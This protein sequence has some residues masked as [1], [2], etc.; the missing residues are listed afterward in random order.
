MDEYHDIK[1]QMIELLK[2]L[3]PER[4]A[5][6]NEAIRDALISA[7]RGQ[8]S[9]FPIN[10]MVNLSREEAQRICRKIGLDWETEEMS[11]DE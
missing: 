1:E 10:E 3:S 9:R 7:A 6:V 8:P 2:K 5:E 11:R 4:L